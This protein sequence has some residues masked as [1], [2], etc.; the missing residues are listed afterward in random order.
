MWKVHQFFQK[1]FSEVWLNVFLK[2]IDISMGT[3]NQKDENLLSMNFVPARS[4]IEDLMPMREI[5]MYG[6]GNMQEEQK[7]RLI[8]NKSRKPFI[9]WFLFNESK[10]RKWDCFKR[11]QNVSWCFVFK[12]WKFCWLVFSRS[13]EWDFFSTS[14]HNK[15]RTIFDLS[16]FSKILKTARWIFIKR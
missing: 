2:V 13:R 1:W 3:I 16:V 15:F 10:W 14:L 11:H 9:P 8:S 12:P 5:M 7:S 4:V 6:K